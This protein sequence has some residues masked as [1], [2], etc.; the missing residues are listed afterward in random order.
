MKKIILII[1]LLIMLPS[2][3]KDCS[4]ER[5]NIINKYQDLINKASGYK[6]EQDSL[7]GEMEQRLATVD[8]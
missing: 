4:E 8:C 3:S 1:I 2:C 5:N 7:R 6:E